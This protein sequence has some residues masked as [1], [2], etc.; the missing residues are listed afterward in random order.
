MKKM[1]FLERDFFVLP[2]ENWVHCA[3]KIV[4]HLKQNNRSSV[5][6]YACVEFC[7]TCLK[8]YERRKK[9]VENNIYEFHCRYFYLLLRVALSV[10]VLIVVA[11]FSFVFN[12]GK[13]MHVHAIFIRETVCCCHWLTC[14]MF[15]ETVL[16]HISVEDNGHEQRLKCI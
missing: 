6:F 10:T 8:N 7:R 13:E 15:C 3:A 9:V 11:S 14:C 16:F 4:F 5:A 12:N 2:Q 1:V